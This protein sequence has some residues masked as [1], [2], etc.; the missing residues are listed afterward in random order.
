MSGP[1]DFSA[2]FTCCKPACSGVKKMTE[3]GDLLTLAS[4]ACWLFAQINK[5]WCLKFPS[6]STCSVMR[7]IKGET[8][9]MQAFGVLRRKRQTMGTM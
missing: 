9:M 4:D 2:V 3:G 8:T 7:V 6:V 5:A 1:K